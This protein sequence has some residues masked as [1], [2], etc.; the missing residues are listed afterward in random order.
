MLCS[1]VTGRAMFNLIITSDTSLIIS[2]SL[3]AIFVFHD[4]SPDHY[5]NSKRLVFHQKML[6]I[7]RVLDQNMTKILVC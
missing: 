7:S 6:L 5:P 2:L 1:A 4:H 3:S